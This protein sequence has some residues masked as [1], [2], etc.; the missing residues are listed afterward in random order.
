[1]SLSKFGGGQVD[2]NIPEGDCAIPSRDNVC[3]DD[4]DLAKLRALVKKPAA[5][6][7]A[8]VEQIKS[9][10]GV[11]DEVNIWKHPEVRAKLGVAA[12]EILHDYYKV[13][14]PADSTA[15]LTNF[16]ID[17][18]IHQWD[19]FG[20]LLFGKK[21]FHIPFQMIDF[22]QM[23]G[24][25]AEFDPHRLIQEGYDSF[26]VVLN[27]DVSSGEGKHW[28]CLYGDLRHKGTREDPI[29][30]EYFNSSGNPPM[31]EII[32]WMESVG[33]RMLR[34]HRLHCELIRS[35]P[36]RLQHSNTECGMWCL[37]YIRSRL[38]G[39][40][41]DWFYKVDADDQDMISY[42]RKLFRKKS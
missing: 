27:T 39:H 2:L 11:V 34:D 19:K 10:L 36:R 41:P 42:R 38:E 17:D 7:E 4:R 14:G 21:F 33:H 25:L 35:A 15:L 26:G 16:N 1:M 28:F 23:G 30:L 24:E 29:Q 18:N 20:P 8:L 32:I 22:M 37:I 13:E 6:R 12:D 31:N 5:K 9:E 3:V 40:P